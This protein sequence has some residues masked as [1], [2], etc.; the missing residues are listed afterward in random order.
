MSSAPR[1]PNDR[2]A[3]GKIAGKLTENRLAQPAATVFLY[4]AKGTAL[5]KATTKADGTFEFKDLPPGAYFL[6]SEKVP[7]NRE[8]KAAV[9]VKAGETTTKELELL[10]K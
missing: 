1:P 10:L 8:V 7:T 6:F 2:P 5:A 3:P 9:E 4:D